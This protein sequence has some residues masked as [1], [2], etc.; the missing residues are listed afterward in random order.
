MRLNSA[1]VLRGCLVPRIV[2]EAL[3]GVLS[4]RNKASWIFG[5]GGVVDFG[6]E[7]G[8]GDSLGLAIKVGVTVSAGA[9]GTWDICLASSGTCFMISE[10]GSE[11]SEA[12]FGG[13]AV[14]WGMSEGG[15]GDSVDC[16]ARSEA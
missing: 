15:F 16:F 5:L 7:S 8:A 3:A 14:G 1:G 4:M 13:C 2:M 11:P 10:N 6:C 12:C 9:F